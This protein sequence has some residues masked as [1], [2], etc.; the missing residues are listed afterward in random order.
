[1]KSK[2]GIIFLALFF[3]LL[4]PYV[5]EAGVA[6]VG[7]LIHEREATVGE[8]YQGI[9]FVR[10]SSEQ[11]QEI[12]VYQTDYLFFFDGRSIYGEPG[13]MKRSNAKWISFSPKQLTIPANE[14]SQVNY[15]I[16][17]PADE[18]LVGTYWS[19]LMI[20]GI[21]EM[22]PEATKSKGDQATLGIRQV[23]RY[24]IQITTHIGDTG[25]GRL[26]FLKTRLLREGERRIL[27]VDIENIGERLLKSFLW[28]EL[29]DEEGS[30]VGRFEGGEFHIRIY[31]GTSV[32]YRVDL[33]QVP[34]GA[35]RALVVAD[36]GGEDIFGVTYTLEL[37]E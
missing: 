9:I 21:S 26:E 20:E 10:N 6:I 3:Y 24:G 27:Q 1:M 8:S 34:K 15:T 12:K 29:Y 33:S 35:Y 11:S 22:L 23:I 16:N 37:E 5:A 18:T 2:I 14:V 36:C 30:Y 7:E 31:P 25:V 17:V 4:I 28:A 32:R 13:R 19:I